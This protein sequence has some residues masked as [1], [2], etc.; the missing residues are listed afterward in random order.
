MFGLTSTTTLT[1]VAVGSLLAFIGALLVGVRSSD[2]SRGRRLLTRG[3]PLAVLMFCSVL[4]AVMAFGLQ[5]NRQ[6]LFYTSWD[7]LAG[8]VGQ[9]TKIDTSGLVAKGQGR[10][11]VVDVP[12]SGP[13]QNNQVLMWL[14]PQYDDPSYKNHRFPVVMFMPGQP[15]APQI[16]FKQY[17]FASTASK[18]IQAGRVAPFV[19][20]FPTIMIS[21]PR[22]TECTD[23]ANGPQAETWLS[24]DVPAYVTKKYRVAPLG[25]QWSAM[26]WSTG[27]FCAAKLMAGHPKSFGSAVS[28]GGYYEPLLD[29]TT[30]DLFGGDVDLRHQNSPEWLYRNN[31]G[32]RGGR[33]LMIAG[34]EDKETWPSTQKMQTTTKGDADVSTIDFPQGG[35]NYRNY[36]SYLAAALRWNAIR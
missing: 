7:D 22:D 14:P 28:F 17:D 30:G 13:A 26:G 36:E 15:S 18:E 32:L 21:P 6:Y 20:V 24:K 29:N 16:V 19:A 8:E 11:T 10:V 25:T 23:V 3:L 2:A 33:L 34:R 35:H 12:A 1:V 4:L 27:G 31:D 9:T 5:L